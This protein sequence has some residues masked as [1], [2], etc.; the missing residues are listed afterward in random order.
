MSTHC[1]FGGVVS[2]ML[3]VYPMDS[4]TELSNSASRKKEMRKSNRHLIETDSFAT[5][6]SNKKPQK[7]L[8][9]HYDHL[10]GLSLPG[11]SASWVYVL[12]FASLVLG[13]SMT[14]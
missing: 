2:E 3:L 6:H 12:F 10:Q 9:C 13:S 1:S 11:G 5:C 14:R 7:G 4:I 8:G